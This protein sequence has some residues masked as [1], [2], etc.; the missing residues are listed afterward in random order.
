M[1]LEKAPAATPNHEFAVHPEGQAPLAEQTVMKPLE[2]EAVS[3]HHFGIRSQLQE[4]QLAQRMQHI[5]R[6][7]RAALGL[8][9]RM[10]FLKIRL[11]TEQAHPLLNRKIFRVK[12]NTHDGTSETHESLGKLAQLDLGA[13]SLETFVEH[14][15]FTV[16]RPTLDERP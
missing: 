4:H 7:E 9:T 6:I 11:I 8:V 10:A 14:E 16:V 13:V 5:P 2:R 1:L 15:L 3:L 12:P